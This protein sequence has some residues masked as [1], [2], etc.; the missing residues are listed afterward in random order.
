M[1]RTNPLLEYSPAAGPIY[2]INT[3]VHVIT[4][5]AYGAI[6]RAC[7]DSGMAWLNRDFRATAGSK[8]SRSVDTRIEFVLVE[9]KYHDNKAWLNQCG[10]SPSPLL[11]SRSPPSPSPSHPPPSASRTRSLA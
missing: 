4:D 8:A 11:P 6:S 7:V 10:T 5:G 3:V 2:R 1:S 9:V